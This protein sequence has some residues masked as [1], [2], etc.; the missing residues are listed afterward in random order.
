M[1]PRA[2]KVLRWTAGIVGALV[3]VIGGL[4]WWGL[5]SEGAAKLLIAK[6]LGGGNGAVEIGAV[7]GRLRGPL[8]LTRVTTKAPTYA[9]TIDSM[10][11]EW[12]PSGLI[13]RQVRIDRLHVVGLHIVLPDS[14][15]RDTAPK[16]PKLPM[17]V[18]LRDVLVQG[19]TVDAPGDIRIR[20]GTVRLDGRAENY[21]IA[22]HATVAAPALKS[23]AP[24]DLT[25]RGNLEQMTLSRAAAG[26]LDGRVLVAGRVGWYPRVSWNLAV[27]ADRV[28]PAT[29]LAD[30]SAWPGLVTAWARTE[31][32]IDT[33]GPVGRAVVDS[34]SGELRKQPLR[35]TLAVNFA[36][37]RY[38]IPAADISWGSAH[39]V[40]SGL[41]AD[42]VDLR[43]DMN[44]GNLATAMPGA[45]GA[46][47]MKGTA[48]GPRL[49][50]RIVTTVD[51][52]G[53]AFGTN[54]LARL[55]GRA[56]VNLAEGGQNI[57]DLR[58]ERATVGATVIDRITMA[59][60]GTQANHRVT[61]TANAPQGTLRLALAGRLRNKA[62]A[63]RI[64][65]L[66]L[67]STTAG[68][69]LLERSAAL[70]ANAQAAALG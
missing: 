49:T 43:Y 45:R 56:D 63:G 20:N 27:Q 52:R 70:S 17:D 53:L 33:I 46:L 2:R 54:R 7:H 25:G 18:L 22:A 50:P 10:V 66:D 19:L 58:A 12:T 68:H 39:A 6:A 21:R 65:A 37:Q 41:V 64:G 29:M 40:A 60:R 32:Q 57:V 8:Y 1:S 44:I 24:L 61:A 9:A 69:W 51:G 28:R 59:L 4:V 26:V 55:T 38:E 5:S 48:A 16:R 36:G 67:Q 34:I 62:W 11:L 35:G 23:A 13:R 31:G 3:L 42:S 47:A 14:A 30:P 15:P